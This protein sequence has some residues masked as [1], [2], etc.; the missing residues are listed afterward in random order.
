MEG[1]FDII[2]SLAGSFVAIFALIPL[3]IKFPLTIFLSIILSIYIYFNKRVGKI[4]VISYFILLLIFII[5]RIYAGSSPERILL[6]SDNPFLNILK[7]YDYVY[8][9]FGLVL[10]LVISNM[11]EI[12]KK[13]KSWMKK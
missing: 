12:V 10:F 9:L 4:I 8:L 3:A 1:I 7:T 13:M 5:I 11:A 6:Y 2:L